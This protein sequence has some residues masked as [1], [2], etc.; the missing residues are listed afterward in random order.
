MNRKVSHVLD[1][2]RLGNP[3]GHSCH[4]KGCHTSV[5]PAMFMCR[6]H[7]F[8]VPPALRSRIWQMYEPGQEQSKDASDDYLR[9]AS[10]AIAAVAAKEGR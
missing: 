8:M 3:T 9:V 2:A 6:R 7:W 4:A 1:E 5:P 10:E